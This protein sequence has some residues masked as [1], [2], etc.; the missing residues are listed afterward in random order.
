[1]KEGE[2]PVFQVGVRGEEGVL[3]IGRSEWGRYLQA[4]RVS[5]VIQVNSLATNPDTGL[6]EG[7][8]P[9]EV[10]IRGVNSLFW[11]ELGRPK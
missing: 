9:V 4:L 5:R 8:F 7:G 3:N 6:P 1:M 11:R 2:A 10:Q